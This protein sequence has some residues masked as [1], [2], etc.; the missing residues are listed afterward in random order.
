[1]EVTLDITVAARAGGNWVSGLTEDPV[2]GLTRAISSF[3]DTG[4]H[5]WTSGPFTLST[6]RTVAI[7]PNRGCQLLTSVAV[8]F[9]STPKI[10]SLL[11]NATSAFSIA[12]DKAYLTSPAPVRVI[13]RNLYTVGA[14]GTIS[15]TTPGAVG[16][17]FN[18]APG[19]RYM[20]S[21]HCIDQTKLLSGTRRHEFE[22]PAPGERSHKGNCLKALRALDPIKFA[23]GLV[24]L[25][26]TALD[27]R[28]QIQA[29]ISAVMSVAATHDIV[30]EAQTQTD[31]IVRFVAGQQIL[32]V[33]L[34]NAGNLIGPVWNPTTNTQL[35]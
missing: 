14:G 6:P 13:P 24:R 23:E 34:D 19:V 32:G 33:N 31:H 5:N 8:T 18:I 4:E 3:H 9:R 25:P 12:Q 17:Y 20:M 29:R 22:D 16:S 1:L 10:N 27:F 35:R 21:P 28:S 11:S 15:E 7:G 2:G 30:D 26:G